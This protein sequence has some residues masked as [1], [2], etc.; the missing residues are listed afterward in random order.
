M[1]RTPSNMIPLGTKAPNFDLQDAISNKYLTLEK[2]KGANA[3]VVFFIC[4]HCPFVIHVNEELVKIANDYSEKEISFID[5]TLF[6]PE[7]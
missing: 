1:S 6:E 7:E 2:L 5:K 4:N 3:T